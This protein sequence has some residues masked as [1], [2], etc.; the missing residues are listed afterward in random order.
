MSSKVLSG[1]SFC[2]EKAQNH[3]SHL[4]VLG[5]D[6]IFSGILHS[7]SAFPCPGVENVYLYCEKDF[8]GKKSYTRTG[9]LRMAQRIILDFSLLF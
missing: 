1:T 3:P 8:P 6:L 4:K 5:T 2:Q 7:Q 9:M